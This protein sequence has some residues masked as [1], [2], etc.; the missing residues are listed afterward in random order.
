MTRHESQPIDES[1]PPPEIR[2]GNRP[3]DFMAPYSDADAWTLP[4]GRTFEP[5][6]D[7]EPPGGNDEDAQ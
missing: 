1:A 2:G 4:D 6:Y 3:E 7:D 5:D